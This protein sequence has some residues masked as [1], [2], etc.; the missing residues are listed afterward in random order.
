MLSAAGAVIVDE[1]DLESMVDYGF[2][3]EL[4]VLLAE[5]KVELGRYLATRD[6]DGPQSM[7]DVVAFN[8]EHADTEL[9]WFGQSFFEQA[10]DAPGPDSVE[11]AEA[12]A[13]CLGRAV[14]TGSTPC[15]AST[16]SMRS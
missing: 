9:Q 12:R 3:D 16:S 11:Y 7:A 14:T 2:D 10:V 4:V 5:F 8:R 13:K 15:C 6:G 1:T